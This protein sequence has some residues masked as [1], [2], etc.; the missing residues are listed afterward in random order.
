M[1]TS[2]LKKNLTRQVRQIFTLVL[3]VSLFTSTS[4][5]DPESE[6]GTFA[7]PSFIA[8]L[9]NLLR[10]KDNN[11]N[12]SY[13]YIKSQPS[14]DIGTLNL[15]GVS[16]SAEV[17]PPVA[18]PNFNTILRD[19]NLLLAL[20]PPILA[21]YRAETE[22]LSRA[23]SRLAVG[24]NNQ[25]TIFT[26]EAGNVFEM[27]GYWLDADRLKVYESSIPKELREQ[28]VRIRNDKVQYLFLVHP[29]SYSMYKGILTTDLETETYL[30][31]ATSSSRSVLTWKE[32]QEDKA[33]IAKVSL[34]VEIATVDRS[35]KGVE[36]AM[37]IGIDRILRLSNLPKSFKYF[38]EVLGIIPA[39][40][41]RGGMIIRSFP[42]EMRDPDVRL[43]P[44]FSLYA[45]HKTERPLLLEMI[46]T[47]GMTPIDFVTSQII[48]PFIG[49]WV[50][51]VVNS[52][53]LTEPHAQNVL[54]EIG[55]DGLPTGSFYH[56]DFGGFNIDLKFRQEKNLAVP[57]LPS[58]TG[59]VASDYYQDSHSG[60][61]HASLF[62]Y[63]NG[64][65][66]SNLDTNINE[67][68]KAGWISGPGFT[69]EEAEKLVVAAL[70]K[71]FAEY[72]NRIRITELEEVTTVVEGLK[73]QRPT[74]PLC[75]SL[76]FGVAQ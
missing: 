25:N 68:I 6:S 48:D 60:N 43:V 45:K 14:V 53:I 24:V 22:R 64:G 71:H 38:R 28:F 40:L 62:S 59:D 18:Q 58:F 17:A 8:R 46:L 47:S 3:I 9:W 66:V 42:K 72:D 65:F 26:P 21:W 16:P 56:R 19:P 61:I 13:V 31:A 41:P 63:F 51:L 20:P 5:S 7:R 57:T 15:Q 27:T 73:S 67:W 69:F 50:D 76:F 23:Y 49:Q 33:F 1:K 44:L 52:G 32:G 37:S 39:G 29:E 36:T 55:K 11:P 35:I 4:F 70:N 30:A 2:F 34:N 75:E 10:N 54:I 12:P 74:A